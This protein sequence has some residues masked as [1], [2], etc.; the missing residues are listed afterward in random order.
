MRQGRLSSAVVAALILMTPGAVGALTFTRVPGL[1]ELSATAPLIVRGRVVAVEY[2]LIRA[3]ET[4]VQAV[5]AVHIEVLSGLKG[6]QAGQVITLRQLGG[7]LTP[8]RR[9]WWR[10]PGIPSYEV[11]EEVVAFIDD[12]AHPFFGTT[13]GDVGLFRIASD[14]DGR[15]LVLNAQWRVLANGLAGPRVDGT[16]CRP[17][18]FDRTRCARGGADQADLDDNA[19]Q[20]LVPLTVEALEARIRAHRGSPQAGP[21]QT[22]SASSS[23]FAQA[24]MALMRQDGATIRQ[25]TGKE[26]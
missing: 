22:V 13:Y 18:P 4:R 6:A 20:S 1:D 9:R 25:L 21:V 10:V 5:T 3:N 16:S 17:N 26:N 15:R 8:D 12:R 24:V 2:D 11:G 23:V 14:T 19:P 7:P